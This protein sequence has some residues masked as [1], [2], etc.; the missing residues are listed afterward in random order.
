ML[1]GVMR[2]VRFELWIRNIFSVFDLI[3]FE[4][5]WN[6]DYIIVNS[7]DCDVNYAVIS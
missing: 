4:M 5:Q 6:K 1:M 3:Y 2:Y 7:S